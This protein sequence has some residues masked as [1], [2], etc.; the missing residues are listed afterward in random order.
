MVHFDPAMGAHADL[1]FGVKAVGILDYMDLLYTEAIRCA[2][3]G[4]G[5]EGF[6][7][8]FQDHGDIA[9][10]ARQDVLDPGAT[11]IRHHFA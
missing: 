5:I 8:I 11:G 3:A 9:R 6:E 4:A 7:N 10:A 1:V 2:K